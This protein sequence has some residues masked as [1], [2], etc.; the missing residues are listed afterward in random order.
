MPI[1]ENEIA[2]QYVQENGMQF[3]NL[4]FIGAA[5][6]AWGEAQGHKTKGMIAAKVGKHVVQ[7]SNEMA[8]AAKTGLHGNE[9]AYRGYSGL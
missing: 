5:C 7:Y 2:R 4:G 6:I 9:N 3:G 8:K 1:T